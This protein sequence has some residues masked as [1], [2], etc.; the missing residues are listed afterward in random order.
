MNLKIILK[1]VILLFLL[2]FFVTGCAV[3]SPLHRKHLGDSIMKLNPDP[4]EKSLNEHIF[5]RR[6]GSSGGSGVSSG[7]CGC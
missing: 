5:E 2:F 6:E 4:E 3:V 1:R 7:G